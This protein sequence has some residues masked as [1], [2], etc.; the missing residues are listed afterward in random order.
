[1]LALPII[2]PSGKLSLWRSVADANMRW[3][4]GRRTFVLSRAHTAKWPAL[5]YSQARM[6]SW[7]KTEQHPANHKPPRG[8]YAM[9]SSL[10]P[11]G[12]NN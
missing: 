6:Q 1:M 3:L 5:S 7:K 10:L 4:K 2:P 11:S 9:L 8:I 12:A